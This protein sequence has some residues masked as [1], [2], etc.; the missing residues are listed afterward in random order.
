[1]QPNI[2]CPGKRPMQTLP[3]RCNIFFPFGIF[4]RWRC[5]HGGRN[6]LHFSHLSQIPELGLEKEVAVEAVIVS[7][8]NITECSQLSA[9]QH[10]CICKGF[11]AHFCCKYNIPNQFQNSKDSVLITSPPV[12]LRL[13]HKS[14]PITDY[15]S[16]GNLITFLTILFH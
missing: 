2:C 5:W 13:L 12:L 16:K 14:H 4:L 7:S 6:A 10:C 1:M 8:L 11:S 3:L 15:A 9:Q